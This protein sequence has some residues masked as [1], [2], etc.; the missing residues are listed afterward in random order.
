METN[1]RLKPILLEIIA[2]QLRDNTPP[3]TKQTLERLIAE[4]YSDK[5]ARELIACAVTAEILD[6]MKS[7]KPYDNNRYV[8][9]LHD[10]PN[11]PED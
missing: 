2:N 9:A 6:V 1:P 4:G 11:L 5:N 8:K 10:L 7:E 3:E